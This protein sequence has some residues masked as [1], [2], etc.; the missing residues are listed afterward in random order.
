ML[1]PAQQQAHMRLA[2]L[3]KTVHF[4]P[5]RSVDSVGRAEAVAVTKRLNGT[6]VKGEGFNVVPAEKRA[7]NRLPSPLGKARAGIKHGQS[8]KRAFEKGVA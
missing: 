4:R 7:A 8:G 6:A 2:S 1:P 5:E 3:P